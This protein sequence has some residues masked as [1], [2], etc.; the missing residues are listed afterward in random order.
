MFLITDWGKYL[1]HS[2]FVNPLVVRLGSSVCG[3]SRFLFEQGFSSLVVFLKPDN[4]DPNDF[5]VKGIGSIAVPDENTLL[6]C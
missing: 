5:L 6:N 3:V 1:A 2:G 4:L